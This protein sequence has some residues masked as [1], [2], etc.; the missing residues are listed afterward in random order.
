MDKIKEEATG[1]ICSN[2]RKRIIQIVENIDDPKILIK[3]YTVAKTHLE[4]QKEME[5]GD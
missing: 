1:K 4:I 2:Y 3:I 5:Q